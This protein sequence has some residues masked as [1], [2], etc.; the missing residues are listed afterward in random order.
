MAQSL[1]QKLKKADRLPTAPDVALKIVQMN[2]R[3]GAT[4]D[5]FADLINRDPALAVKLLKTANSSMFGI[6]REVTNI[7]QAVMLLGLRSVNLLALS[8]SLTSTARGE[9]D[10]PFDYR[11]YWTHTIAMTVAARYITDLYSP[12]VKDEAFV[13]G[14]LCDIGQLLLA[15]HAPKEYGPV[16]EELESSARPVHEVEQ[17]L[18]GTTHAALG[19]ELLDTWGLPPLLCR[20]VGAHHEPSTLDDSDDRLRALARAV[21]FAS[22]C[23]DVLVAED[24]QLEELVEVVRGRGAEYFEAGDRTCVELLEVVGNQ[25]PDTAN[26]LEVD[27]G[28]PAVLFETRLRASELLIRESPEPGVLRSSDG[29]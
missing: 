28:D 24:G 18:L 12:S 25:L 11:R 14:L 23:A 27:L 16:L 29:A 13:V 22:D 5:E 7:R 6:P 21:H 19:Q 10:L 8:F 2:E 1:L 9:S 20:A 3:D 15:E 17:E 4:V 26:V